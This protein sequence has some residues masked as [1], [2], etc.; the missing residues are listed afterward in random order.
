VIAILVYLV[1]TYYSFKLALYMF[2]FSKDDDNTIKN[3]Q[4]ASAKVDILPVG[5][6]KFNDTKLSKCWK[7]TRITRDEKMKNLLVFNK[8]KNHLSVSTK[9]D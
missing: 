2:D 3:I 8:F 7:I 1:L 6:R 4:I 5:K 9:L